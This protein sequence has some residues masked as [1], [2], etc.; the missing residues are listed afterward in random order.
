MTVNLGL[1]RT[2]TGFAVG[3]E[4]N[5]RGGS[6]FGP[7]GGIELISRSSSSSPAGIRVAHEGRFVGFRASTLRP[8]R[9]PS[10]VGNFRGG[11]A[12]MAYQCC[13]RHATQPHEFEFS[14]CSLTYNILAILQ[15]T[16]ENTGSTNRCYEYLQSTYVSEHL[17]PLWPLS[18]KSR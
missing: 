6:R 16:N 1:E 14:I 15:A 7:Q 17:S 2:C 12:G 8:P 11:Q 4:Y 13:A 5:H 10:K 18:H 3:Q 9:T